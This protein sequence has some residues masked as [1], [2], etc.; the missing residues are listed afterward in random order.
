MHQA[1]WLAHTFN[2]YAIASKKY[3]PFYYFALCEQVFFCHAIELEEQKNEWKTV[4]CSLQTFF[5][6]LFINYMQ[7]Q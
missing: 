6:L 2:I 7:T 1:P 5:F 4:F 3:I